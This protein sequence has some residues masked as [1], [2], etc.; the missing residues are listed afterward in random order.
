MEWYNFLQ[1]IHLLFNIIEEIILFL[2]SNTWEKN[3]SGQNYYR[4]CPADYQDFLH[5]Y[6][7]CDTENSTPRI[8]IC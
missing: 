1:V 5:N 2:S 6:D 4:S 8:K 7:D 3:K